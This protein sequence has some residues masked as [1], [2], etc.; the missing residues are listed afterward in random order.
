[1]IRGR[2]IRT[3]SKQYND[4]KRVFAS[5][6]DANGPTLALA[7]ESINGFEGALRLTVWFY[8]E[9]Q[10]LFTKSGAIKRLDVSNRLKPIEDLVSAELGIDD[11]QF[12]EIYMFK[13]ESRKP[14]V[15]IAIEKLD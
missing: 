3:R 10:K 8:F 1:M 15:S 13:I 12:F 6:C 14:C 4:F 2:L 7:R 9:K 11:R 5:W